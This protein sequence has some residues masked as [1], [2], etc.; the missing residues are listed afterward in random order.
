MCKREQ[1]LSNQFRSMC[2]DR[3]ASGMSVAAIAKELGKTY[4][5]TRSVCSQLKGENNGTAKK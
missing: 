2:K 4:D 3:L 5:H 1:F